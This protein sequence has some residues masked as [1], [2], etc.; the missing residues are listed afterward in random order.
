M[1][2]LHS[3]FSF[4]TG[5]AET[6]LADIV[7]I[8]CK[9]NTVALLIINNIVDENLLATIDKRVKIYR[10]DRNKGAKLQLFTAYFKIRR[11]LKQENPDVIHCHVNRLLPFFFTCRKKT[12]LTLHNVNISC[13]FVKYYGKVFAISE[14]V[15]KY[16]KQKTGINAK[17]VYNGI[18][19]GAYQYRTDYAFNQAD[20]FKIVQISRLRPQQKGQGIAIKTLS[21][22]QKKYPKLNLKLYFVGD[23]TA[24]DELK[25]LAVEN[26][27]E[28]QVIFVGQKNRQW[29]KENLQNFELLIQ[30]S[31]YEG[32]G[33][34]VIEG[35]AAGLP[36]IASNL[37]GPKEL[38][39]IL[40][41]GLLVEPGNPS[42]LAEKI[43][44]V[45]ENYAN[46]TIQQTNFL[47]KDKK[48]IEK[49]D[50]QQTVINYLNE[51]QKL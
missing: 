33:L 22:L 23:G 39:G 45:Y 46:G 51:Y 9:T 38:F 32:F 19:T 50:I 5:G 1:K 6:M 31:F 44:T 28:N 13:R 10:L 43:Y 24:L 11:I 36:V 35:F 26:Q 40:N 18:E 7:N 3:I 21:I 49:F 8:Q 47:L 29:I 27:V 41:S 25:N 12:C 4:I 30:P 14:S 42:D 20:E 48:T 34:T 16:I 2:I 17:I 37:D 15:Q